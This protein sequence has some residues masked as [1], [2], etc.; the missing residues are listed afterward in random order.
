[1]AAVGQQDNASALVSSS[2][3]E[4]AEINNEGVR[5]AYAGNFSEAMGL[6]TRAADLLPNN[7]Q[8][9]SNAALVIALALTREQADP[10]RLSDCVKYR[11]LLAA[12]NPQHAKLA[13]IDGLLVQYKEERNAASR[14]A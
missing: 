3:A 1:M 11:Q 12:R 4:V 5:L 13:Q 2:L 14:S 6:L 9:L 7:M 10:S 8:F